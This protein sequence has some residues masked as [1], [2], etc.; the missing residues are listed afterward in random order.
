MPKQVGKAHHWRWC[1]SAGIIVVASG[2][3]GCI[4]EQTS[5]KPRCCLSVFGLI[6]IF[7]LVKKMVSA[8]FGEECDVVLWLCLQQVKKDLFWLG[9]MSD[10]QLG[11]S[12]EQRGRHIAEVRKI[13]SHPGGYFFATGDHGLSLYG[14]TVEILGKKDIMQLIIRE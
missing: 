5:T 1:L 3:Q 6:Y 13:T 14:D 7:C 12:S 8:C 9:W 2:D 11:S 10:P 4:W